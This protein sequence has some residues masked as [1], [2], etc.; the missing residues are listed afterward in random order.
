MNS[1]DSTNTVLRVKELQELG[2]GLALIA[3]GAAAAAAGAVEASG[4]PKRFLRQARQNLSWGGGVT[5]LCH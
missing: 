3:G 2:E 5:K 1:A 4:P